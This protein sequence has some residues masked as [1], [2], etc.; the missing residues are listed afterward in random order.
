MKRLS[1][2]QYREAVNPGIYV[3]PRG[4]GYGP[5]YGLGRG[6][7]LGMG[8]GPGL[9]RGRMPAGPGYGM[10]LGGECICPDCGYKTVHERANPCLGM[11]C[12]KCGTTMIRD[13]STVTAQLDEI[14]DEMQSQDTR[15]ALAID[16]I[17]DRI[18]REAAMG[19]PSKGEALKT[20]AQIFKG[21]P[22]KLMNIIQKITKIL[23]RGP[24]K[25]AFDIKSLLSLA[26]PKVLLSILAL[27]VAYP[28]AQEIF[29]A[30]NDTIVDQ[31]VIS[32]AMVSI[33]S[34]LDGAQP[35]DLLGENKAADKFL[36]ERGSIWK[37]NDK[38]MMGDHILMGDKHFGVGVGIK[39][40]EKAAVE[41]AEE[42]AKKI[43]GMANEVINTQTKES[44]SGVWV[45]VVVTGVDENI[46]QQVSFVEYFKSMPYW[47]LKDVVK[48]IRSEGK[49]LLERK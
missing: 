7:G 23:G 16:Q 27:M 49:E 11:P 10:G 46:G 48:S 34:E 43:G 9:G 40:S 32:K 45:A 19:L 14:A 17:S 22:E 25:E 37:L 44:K 36:K 47:N 41:E 35:P 1:W 13:M 39:N 2:K 31:T 42:N 30:V 5:A 26:Q 38:D 21:K 4:Y 3:A 28:S 6:P 33:V 8:R 12:P 24:S 29:D 18:E 15:V 20:V